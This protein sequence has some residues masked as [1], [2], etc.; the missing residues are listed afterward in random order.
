MILQTE[1]FIS[2]SKKVNRHKEDYALTVLHSK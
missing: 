2:V 1:L